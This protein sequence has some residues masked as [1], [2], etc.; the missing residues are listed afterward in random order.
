MTVSFKR[1]VSTVCSKSKEDFC[2][3]WYIFCHFFP[4]ISF[5]LL[6]H[7]FLLYVCVCA[8]R[9]LSLNLPHPSLCLPQMSPMIFRFALTR[10]LLHLSFFTNHSSSPRHF[11]HRQFFFS[12]TRHPPLTLLCI[13]LS[14][15]AKAHTFIHSYIVI[16][17]VVYCCHCCCCFCYYF[18][19]IFVFQTH[20]K[21][22]KNREPRL[23]HYFSLFHEHFGIYIYLL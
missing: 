16:V 21:R 20:N 13:C 6:Y 4:L 8:R 17:V 14:Y 15:F 3:G 5:Y 18:A 9:N 22:N 10:T 7:L 1:Q 2:C 19:Y 11:H 12:S 23:L